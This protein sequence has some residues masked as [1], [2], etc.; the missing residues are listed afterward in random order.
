M[1]TRSL[2]STP[3]LRSGPT[4]APGATR[5]NSCRSLPDSFSRPLRRA[6]SGMRELDTDCAKRLSLGSQLVCKDSL[7]SWGFAFP[8]SLDGG[9][10]FLAM[11]RTRRA[12][13]ASMSN[14]NQYRFDSLG[15]KSFCRTRRSPPFNGFFGGGRRTRSPNLAL[16][17]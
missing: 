12:S 17:A 6:A 5:Q 9:S 1:L 8:Y 15:D 10:S 7:L 14:L 16:K 4:T 13:A 3:A 11:N 2:R